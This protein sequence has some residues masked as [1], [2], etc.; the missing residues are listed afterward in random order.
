MSIIGVRVRFANGTEKV[1]SAVRRAKV[2][3]L[4][5]AA[6]AISGTAKRSIEKAARHEP[7]AEGEPPHTHRGA[8]YR[9][10]VRY[11]VERDRFDAVIGFAKSKIGMVG[12]V[13]E[14]GEV[15]SDEYGRRDYPVRPTMLPAL[16]HN[17]GRFHNDWRASIGG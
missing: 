17:L 3:N 7:S 15:E 14:H 12:A 6:A 1:L 5:H 4:R 16:E 13:Q 9:R 2:N 10:A 8:F 11:D